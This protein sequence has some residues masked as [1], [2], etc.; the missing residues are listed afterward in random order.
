MMRTV[1][2]V[3]PAH[4]PQKVIQIVQRDWR[5]M[6][7]RGCSLQ[8]PKLKMPTWNIQWKVQAGV[9]GEESARSGQCSTQSDVESK[10]GAKLRSETG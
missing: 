9:L 4:A 2:L 1:F 7:A 5:D 6:S 3:S 8:D 10:S